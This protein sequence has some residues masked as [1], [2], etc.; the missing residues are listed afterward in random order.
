MHEPSDVT[1][2]IHAA[3]PQRYVASAQRCVS[4]QQ[5]GRQVYQTPTY[6]AMRY[7]VVTANGS[8]SVTL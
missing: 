4:L 8:T 3:Q 1:Q 6:Q 2:G 5:S 7:D